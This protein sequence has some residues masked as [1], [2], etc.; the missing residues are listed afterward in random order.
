MAMIG[1]VF[2]GAESFARVGRAEVGQPEG[3][4]RALGP[5]QNCRRPPEG[6]AR[7]AEADGQAFETCY[8]FY[9]A[10]E[11]ARRLP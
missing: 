8:P 10:L 6:R 2:S 7:V 11:I 3:A 4:C 9:D 5:L 1:S